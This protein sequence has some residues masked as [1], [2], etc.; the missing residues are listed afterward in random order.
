MMYEMNQ[1]CTLHAACDGM[2]LRCCFVCAFVHASQ[3]YA[4][5]G[6]SLFEQAFF[7]REYVGTS[8]AFASETHSTKSDPKKYQ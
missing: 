7:T 3:A 5:G 8:K 6:M 4:I 1:C 2:N